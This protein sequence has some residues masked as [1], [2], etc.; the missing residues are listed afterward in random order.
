MSGHNKWS[1]IKRKK[2]AADAKRGQMFTRLGREIT[3]AAREGG[4]DPDSNFKLR[5]AVDKARAANMP[6]D[7]IERSI[8]RGTGALSG[9]SL[10]SIMYE[11]YGPHGVA[12]LV[13]A[14]TDNRNR[15]VSDLRRAFSRGGGVLAEAGAVGWQFARKGYL[16][17]P[18]EGLDSD[19]I[20]EMTVEAGADDVVPGDDVIEVYAPTDSF[21]AVRQRL[22]EAEVP[23]DEAEI[24]MV[25]NQHIE[26]DPKDTIQVM[27]FIEGLEELD[28]V[29]RVFSNLNV[30][31]EALK[32]YEAEG[33]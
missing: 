23:I 11:G 20:F 21:Q 5:L 32:Q 9:E 30:S 3:L 16:S 26:L 6:K 31:E 29:N 7:N 25:P 28:D 18:A 15:T 4:G 24:T 27:G 19:A 10:E 22:V 14:L 13:D 17:I 1:T 33:A 8:L 2:G 12:V